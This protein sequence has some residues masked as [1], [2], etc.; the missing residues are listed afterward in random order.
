VILD[1]S[2]GYAVDPLEIALKRG[3]GMYPKSMLR[4]SFSA[5]TEPEPQPE[6]KI[7]A[8]QA[9]PPVSFFDSSSD[10]GLDF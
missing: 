5:E 4:V 6:D 2:S 10:D 7:G 8:M 3:N 1:P 9:I